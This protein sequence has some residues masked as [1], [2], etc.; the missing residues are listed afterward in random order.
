MPW[1]AV[2]TLECCPG[3]ECDCMA[4][5]CHFEPWGHYFKPQDRYKRILPLRVW[6]SIVD[7]FLWYTLLE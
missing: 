6:Y 5:N 1:T 7:R 2:H 4:V 3:L